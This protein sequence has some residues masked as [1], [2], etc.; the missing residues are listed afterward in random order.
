MSTTECT[1][2]RMQSPL[3]ML[4]P[5]MSCCWNNNPYYLAVP[6]RWIAVASRSFVDGCNSTVYCHCNSTVTFMTSTDSMMTNTLISYP[7]AWT[8]NFKT[9]LDM[10]L[11]AC[12]FP[13]GIWQQLTSCH[14]TN[15]WST[16]PRCLTWLIEAASR[17]H[18]WRRFRPL[19]RKTVSQLSRTKRPARWMTLQLWESNVRS[20]RRAHGSRP[21]IAEWPPPRPTIFLPLES[22]F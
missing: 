14:A 2:P 6:A 17:G 18:E 12:S 4:P 13:L 22:T 1:N 9:S 8:V 11:S 20:Q 21:H 19:W 3:P 15:K 7:Y 5:I 10:P 16:D